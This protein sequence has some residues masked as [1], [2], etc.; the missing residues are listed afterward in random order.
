MLKTTATQ[1]SIDEFSLSILPIEEKI[2][3]NNSLYQNLRSGERLI[4]GF[5][6]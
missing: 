1:I 3:E 2:E 5:R 4:T 6:T